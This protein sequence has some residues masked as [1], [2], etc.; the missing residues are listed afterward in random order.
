MNS[1]PVIVWL[2]IV[3]LFIA[4]MV[5][6]G[7]TVRL[8]GSGLSMVDWK[9]LIGAIP[10]LG[11]EA[12]TE[13]F[14]MYQQSPQFQKVNH[15][16][17]LADFKRIFFW[18]YI[19]RLLGRLIGVL[20]V[21]PW[22]WF[23][24][25]GRLRG[26][27]AIKTFLAFVLGGLQGL[28]GWYMVRSGL[29]DRPSV[30]HLRL[31]AHLGLALVVAN[32]VLWLILEQVARP[33]DCLNE[34]EGRQRR[35]VYRGALALLALISV[36]VVYGALVAGT[37]AGHL[38]ATFPDFGGSYWPEGIASIDPLWR[39]LRDNPVTL[40][41]LHRG[42]GVLLLILIPMWSVFARRA[43]RSQAQ[44]LAAALMVSL[45]VAQVGLGIVTVLYS[46]PTTLGVAHQLG[47]MALLSC[48]VFAVFVFGKRA[49]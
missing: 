13:K 33:P 19:H 39:D 4:A 27:S 36:Q 44:R 21:V 9:P 47:G 23:V 32:Y 11:E 48:A 2:A 1:R 16:M 35:W 31:A 20:F 28:L 29:V 38:F 6:V 15:W 3:Y 22:M 14:E 42:L 8:T 37:H 25:S 17:R 45:V 24:A 12:W 43:I 30:S 5:A 40:H 10:P 18:E 34:E 7:G 46:V 49:P 26:K 41:V